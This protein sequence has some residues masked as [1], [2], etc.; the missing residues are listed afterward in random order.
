MKTY[1]SCFTGTVHVY[2]IEMSALRNALFL[3]CLVILLAMG[4]AIAHP[5]EG[6][7]VL[8]L[9]TRAYI[10][11]GALA[12][13]AS[14][15]LVTCVSRTVLSRLFRPVQFGQSFSAARLQNATS[16]FG[17]I[18]F[19][20]LIYVGLFGP[21]DP[22]SNLMPLTIWTI[23]WVGLYSVQGLVGDIWSWVNPWSGLCRWVA[24]DIKP[25]FR[26]PI[27]LGAWPACAIFMM[28]QV[29][30]LSDIAPNDPDRLARFAMFYWLFTF[31]GMILFG[32]QN[33]LNQV[34]C[35]TV[36]F[37]L[38]G[39]LRA[40]FLMGKT[41]IG[42]PGWASIEKAPLSSSQ[43]VFCLIILAS[44]SFD[45]L[46]ET[47]WWL[48]QIGVNPLEFPGRS[49]VARESIAGLIGANIALI[50]VFGV[51]V[52]IGIWLFQ[53]FGADDAPRFSTAF[54]TFAI[55]IL[56]IALGYHIAHYLVS[57]LVQIQYVTV[58][59]GDPFAKGWNLFGLSS[60]P[61]TT[62]FLN[63]AETVKTIWLTQ[64]T[65]VVVSHILSVLMAHHL[66][67]RFARGGRDIMLLQ[68]GISVLMVAYTVF[69]LWLLA[70]PRG[71]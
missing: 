11:A 45:G 37:R 29:F 27:W 61:V 20:F 34:E 1:T 71:A 4:A 22:L 30:I 54:N 6:G 24:R 33:W 47:F 58:T 2:T 42:L 19:G 9:P 62:G 51:S 36:L 13:V 23:W 70:S 67:S 56:P 44:G 10:T 50:G 26:L 5:A 21:N 16:I 39:S 64:A 32:Q 46:Q 14:I 40:A 28:F 18:F 31:T 65:V 63:T 53:Q 60:T 38:I 52:Y 15:I 48:A 43:A 12:V 35:F 17:T 25:M 59:L 55:S 41:Q 3:S 69:G 8:L 49:A 66:A 7:F 57:F 68:L